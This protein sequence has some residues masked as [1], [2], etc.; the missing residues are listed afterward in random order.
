MLSTLVSFTWVVVAIIVALTLLIVLVVS[1]SFG[2]IS[3]TISVII[4]GIIMV[5]ISYV[6][7]EYT[8]YLNRLED[9]LHPSYRYSYLHNNVTESKVTE[10]PE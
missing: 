7:W 5:G 8:A 10:K 3:N 2:V 4:M 9:P 6:L 1:A